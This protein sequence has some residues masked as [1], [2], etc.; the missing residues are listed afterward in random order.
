MK[1]KDYIQRIETIIED[2][3][4]SDVEDMITVKEEIDFILSMMYQDCEELS[5]EE[6]ERLEQ[7]VC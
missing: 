7:I 6:N 5:D 3:I 2:R 4:I 1:V